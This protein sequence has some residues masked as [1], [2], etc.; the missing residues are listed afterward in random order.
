MREKFVKLQ[1]QSIDAVKEKKTFRSALETAQVGADDVAALRAELA[2]AKKE[3]TG[4]LQESSQFMQMKKMMMQKTKELQAARKKL[5]KY[6]PDND[7]DVRS[8]DHDDDD[9]EFNV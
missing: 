3:A 4:R 7:S 5:R 1:G 8:A 9:D 2:A 6:E